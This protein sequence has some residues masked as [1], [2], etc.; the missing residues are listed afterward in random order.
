MSRTKNRR[1]PTTPTTPKPSAPPTLPT[2]PAQPLDRPEFI[3]EQQMA[4]AYAARLA[5]LPL[6]PITAWQ[7][8][9]AGPRAHFPGGATLTHTPTGF[10]ASTPC[11]QGARHHDH[12]TTGT[13]LRAAANAA[14]HCT[15]IH[16]RP[17]LLTLAQAANAN[18]ETQTLTRADINA[19]LAHRAA[20]DNDQMKEHPA[21]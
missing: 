4:A 17:R 16:G 5:E 20:A 7:P 13:Q 18:D 21:S 19:G 8:H 14:T 10:T 9:P 3:T 15:N 2:R 1:R 6:I 12:I 11:P